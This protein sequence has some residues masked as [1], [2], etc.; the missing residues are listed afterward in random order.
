MWYPQGSEQDGH[1]DPLLHTMGGKSGR[2][3]SDAGQVGANW[4]GFP[5]RMNE[6]Y[7]QRPEGKST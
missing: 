5:G 6:Q 2:P 4:K 1:W 3:L 7:V